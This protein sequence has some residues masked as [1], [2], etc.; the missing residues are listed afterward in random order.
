MKNIIKNLALL[1]LP[2]AAS[3]LASSLLSF[4]ERIFLAHYSMEALEA[5]FAGTYVS[6]M[7]YF[8]CM[9][10]PLMAQAFIGRYMGA[11]QKSSVGPCIWQM[12]WLSVFSFLISLPLSFIIGKYYFHDTDLEQQA[13]QYFYLLIPLN[14]FYPLIAAFS[15]F[16]VAIGRSRLMLVATLS[17]YLINLL[18]SYAFIFGFRDWIPSLGLYGA[19][20][21]CSLAQGGLALVLWA[22]FLRTNYQE[23]YRT[24]LWVLR[25]KELW[26]YLR[27]GLLSITARFLSNSSWAAI[28]W[29][30]LQKGTD[31]L[32]VLSVGGTLAIFTNFVGDSLFQSTL[33]MAS[34]FIGARQYDLLPRLMRSTFLILCMA[35]L[36]I[37]IP[38]L[39][40][41]ETWVPL[42]FSAEKYQEVKNLILPLLLGNW[43][44]FFVYTFNAIPNAFIFAFKDF[45]FTVLMGIMNWIEFFCLY[46]LI[47]FVGIQAHHFWAAQAGV[48]LL[49][50]SFLLYQRT[51]ILTARTLSL[52]PEKTGV[53]GF[54]TPNQKKVDL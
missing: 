21:S 2:L 25:P 50:E 42:L 27:S 52:P 15:A 8:P 6:R 38:L 26:E 54:I 43:L 32:F 22:L 41:P 34:R 31:F 44:S 35:T 40:F 16:F 7:F 51:R 12:I 3:A 53:P 5:S 1:F 45:K 46:G 47:L 28:T 18:L 33:N 17:G 48:V 9:A 30:I 36:L 20:V 37:A 39:G 4:I 13:V 23:T 29:L 24:D 10:V 14:L 49:C 11:N 19:G